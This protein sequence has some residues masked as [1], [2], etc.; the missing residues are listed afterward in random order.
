MSRRTLGII[1]AA[2]GLVIMAVSA[3]ADRIGLGAMPAV[4]GWKQVAGA[5]VGVV[6]VIGGVLAVRR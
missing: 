5:V 6:L 2:I 4:F 3:L 1:A